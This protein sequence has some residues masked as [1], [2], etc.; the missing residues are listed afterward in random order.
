MSKC[1]YCDIN[2]MQKLSWTLCSAE[3]YRYDLDKTSEFVGM[4]LY[5]NKDKDFWYLEASGDSYANKPIN[6]CPFCGRQ[7]NKSYK[8]IR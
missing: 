5:Y 4:Y 1:K 2:K 3:T 6:F 7:L 8:A